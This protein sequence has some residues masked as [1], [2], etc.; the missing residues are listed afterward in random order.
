MIILLILID[1]AHDSLWISLA[2]NWF[3]ALMGLKGLNLWLIRWPTLLQ[4]IKIAK[5]HLKDVTDYTNFIETTKV[6]NRT[7]LVSVWEMLRLIL[8]EN[9]FPF[10]GKHYH[11]PTV[12]RWAQRQQFRS[13]IFMAYIET[14][15]LIKQKPSLNQL[16]ENAT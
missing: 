10:N 11:R 6:K 15:S 12:P 5:S 7:F 8:K 3:W 16:F 9:S 14:Q 2:E 4:P 13:N 1:F